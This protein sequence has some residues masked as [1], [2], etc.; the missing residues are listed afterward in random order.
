MHE[1]LEAD[2]DLAKALLLDPFGAHPQWASGVPGLG[3]HGLPADPSYVFLTLD[4]RPAIGVV[5]A[6]VR[7][8]DLAATRG[9]LLI[10]ARARSTVPGTDQVRVRTISL[11]LA[12]LARSGGV[13]TLEFESY[14]NALYA[15]SGSINDETDATASHISVSIDRRATAEQHGKALG[16]RKGGG[17]QFRANSR[18]DVTAPMIDRLL[19]DLSP[20]RLDKP[21]S[22]VGSPLQCREPTFAEAMFALQRPAEPSFENWSL[23]YVLSAINRFAGQPHGS[24]LGFLDGSEAPLLSHFAKQKYEIIGMRHVTDPNRRVDP[25]AELQRLWRPELCD[26]DTFFAHAHFAAGDIRLPP[27]A[28]RDQFDIVWSIGANRAM[29]PAEFVNF[30]VHGLSSAKPGGIAVHVFDYVEDVDARDGVCLTRHDIE[31]LA[32]LALSHRN[33][34]AQLRFR[35]EATQIADRILPFGIVLRRGGVPEG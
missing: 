12:E 6:T 21:T 11:N 15:I 23:A 8:F 25:G 9:T 2:P 31:R 22:Q 24:V 20:P 17:D 16:G 10:E 35:H 26:E 27:E 3:G 1:A 13:V 18:P 4:C 14:R 5:V 30:V 19:A 33:D 7:F 28:F 34:V 32:I 29:S